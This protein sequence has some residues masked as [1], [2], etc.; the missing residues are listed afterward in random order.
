MSAKTC[1]VSLPVFAFGITPSKV[2]N[3]G[4]EVVLRELLSFCQVQVDRVLCWHVLLSYHVCVGTT[5]LA[6]ASGVVPTQT[7]DAQGMVRHGMV[8]HI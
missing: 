6:L 3:S 4:A 7:W 1:L 2:T 5:P 8:F